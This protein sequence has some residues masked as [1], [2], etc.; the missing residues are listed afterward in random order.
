M[1]T[2]QKLRELTP[3]RALTLPEALRIAEL[4][5]SRLLTISGI[6]Q[7]PVAEHIIA[8]LP[9]LQV[10]RIKLAGLSGAAEWSHGRWLIILN[11]TEVP[12]RQRFSL[13]HEFKHVLDNPFIDVL[14]PRVHAMS[15]A[16]RAE[17]VCDYFAGCLLMP[18]RWLTRHWKGGQQDS[19]TLAALYDVSGAAMRVRLTQIGLA[20]GNERH[21]PGTFNERLDA[22]PNIY[23]RRQEDSPCPR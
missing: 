17:A 18:R 5:A 19:R 12:T 23:R 7:P 3:V 4:Q 13:A 22:S 14:Y 9:R 6:T 10:E 2:I 15:P 8:G 20:V 16:D 1:G 11:G 21:Q